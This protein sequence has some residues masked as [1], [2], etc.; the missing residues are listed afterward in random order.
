MKLYLS[1]QSELNRWPTDLQSVALPTELYSE[2]MRRLGIEPRAKEWKSSM[3][4]LHQ[5]HLF[6]IRQLRD[7][8]SRGFPH[9]LSRLTP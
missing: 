6:L 2:G 3:L 5:R 7:L 9:Q 1:E 8:N 4:P